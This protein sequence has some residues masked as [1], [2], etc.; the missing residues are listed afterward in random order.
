M[1]NSAPGEPTMDSYRTTVLTLIMAVAIGVGGAFFLT[2]SNNV[3]GQ[4]GRYERVQSFRGAPAIPQM[5]CSQFR[6]TLAE[7]DCEAL[8]RQY[9]RLPVRER[10]IYNGATQILLR[11]KMQ[12]GGAPAP[13]PQG[14]YALAHQMGVYQQDAPLVYQAMQDNYQRELLLN[15]REQMLS[16]LQNPSGR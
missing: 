10:N 16:E 12:G 4:Y 3:G 9:Y 7:R 1:R 2:S 6:G 11:R 14:A 13:S 5:D 8:N 15:Q